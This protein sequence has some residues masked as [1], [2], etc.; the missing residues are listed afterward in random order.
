MLTKDIR[1]YFFLLV[2]YIACSFIVYS[3]IINT[4]FLSDDFHI[5]KTIVNNN[6]FDTALNSQQTFFR[7]LFYLSFFIDYELW[8]LNPSGYHITNILIHSLNSFLI[9]LITFILL[10]KKQSP[11]KG[12]DLPIFSGLLFIFLPCHVEPVTFIGARA[13]IIAALFCFS[14]FCAYLKYKQFENKFYLL[15][16]ILLFIC[17]LFSKE[18]AFSYPFVILS[19]EAYCYIIQQDKKKKFMHIIYLPLT[20]CVTFLLYLCVRFAVLGTIIGG[21]GRSGQNVHL[22]FDLIQV[23]KNIFIFLTRT[24][25]PPM[26]TKTIAILIFSGLL[27]LSILILLLI[28]YSKKFF[29]NREKKVIPKIFYF[30]I[31]AY[32]VLLIPVINLSGITL[33]DLRAERVL[34]LPSAFATIFIIYLYK[35]IIHNKK[36]LYIFFTS[37]LLLNGIIL[38]RSNEHYRKASIISKSILNSIQKLSKVDRLYII[39]LPDQINGAYTFRTGIKEAISLFCK[40]DQFKNVTDISYFKIYRMDDEVEVTKKSNAYFVRSLNPKSCFVSAGIPMGFDFN[41]EYFEIKEFTGNSYYLK[42]KKFNKNDKLTFYSA[43]KL[44]PYGI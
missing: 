30:L 16:S 25:L 39:N 2:F 31:P 36:Y 37:L 15:I 7:P 28:R 38:Y 13:D 17:A 23:S 12:W 1:N 4:F 18:S 8:N 3:N 20:Y 14:S 26:P 10:N 11:K 9:F 5:L 22:N 40:S 27:V 24:F 21:Y 34:Y 32:F 43:G 33:L 35:F 41:T 44:I 42:L 19:Y 29:Q 6:F